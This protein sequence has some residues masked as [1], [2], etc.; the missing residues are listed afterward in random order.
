[1]KTAFV[2]P[3]HPYRGGIAH[4]GARLAHE[5]NNNHE[6]QF[7]NFTRL[8][9]NFLFPGKTQIDNSNSPIDF[10]NERLID[11]ISPRSW[12]I[13]GEHIRNYD[14]DA[15]IFHWWHPFFGP[16]YRAIA[17]KV[18]DKAIKVAI[19]HNVLPH[20]HN[21]LNRIAVKF[22]LK[23]MDGSI[24][25]SLDDQKTFNNLLTNRPYLKLFHPL[26]D[27]FPH[28]TML[29]SEARDEIGLS[30]E[31]RVVLY[32]GLIR[33][34]KGVEVLLNAAKHLK[35]IQNLK[36]LIVGEIYSGSNSIIQQIKKLPPNMVRLVNQYVPNDEVSTWFRAADIVALPYLSA[37]QSGVVPIAYSCNRPVIVTNVGGLPEIVLD[38]ESGYLIEAR[39]SL[40][41]A[42]SIRQHF[43]ENGNP[44]MKDGI[45]KMKQK[46]SWSTYAS[47]LIKF[48]ES[49]S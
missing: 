44:S 3:A 17:H 26:Y 11:S 47:E 20:D 33:P 16:A 38:K 36:I 27:I 23:K 41:L 48:I 43:I 28:Q 46:L 7:I 15:M 42:H 49:L 40:G 14:C 6:I 30:E 19:C 10:P 8:Y 35:D 31:D 1:M 4:F 13:T 37:T 12:R 32:F 34:Y 2:G 24:L 5:L 18:G 45:K 9:P 39:D 22:G 25:H 29:R 21:A